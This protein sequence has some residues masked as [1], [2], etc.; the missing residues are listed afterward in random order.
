MM[1]DVQLLELNEYPLIM[2]A[3]PFYK[4]IQLMKI[5]ELT[6]VPLFQVIDRI[7][8]EPDGKVH[9]GVK[10]CPKCWRPLEEENKNETANI[11]DDDISWTDLR[12]YLKGE[13]A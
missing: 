5:G 6:V 3:V 4:E 9:N 8:L 10:V 1:M 13:R 7:I 11:K 2:K 12:W